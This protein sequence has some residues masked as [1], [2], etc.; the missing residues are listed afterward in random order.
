MKPGL[1]GNLAILFEETEANVFY[2]EAKH[3]INL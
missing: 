3:D 1:P 2:S